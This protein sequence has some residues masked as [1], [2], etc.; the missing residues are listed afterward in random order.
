[1]D[2]Q[3]ALLPWEVKALAALDAGDRDS[4]LKALMEGLEQKILAY[5]ILRLGGDPEIG[6]DVAHEVFAAV[7]EAFPGFERKASLETWTFV[8]ARNRCAKRRDMI[9]HFGRIFSYG[10]DKTIEEAHP[11]PSDPPDEVVIKHQ[12][13][14]QLRRA[15]GKLR[16][17]ERDL[18]TM[19]YIEGLSLEKIAERYSVAREN[20]RLQL[21]K[22]L[23]KLKRVMD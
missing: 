17:K 1:M 8:I 20:V 2:N 7:W 14:E 22:A 21:L 6:K 18:V 23:Q 19:Y 9:R 13:I 10:I 15:M 11:D 16:H 4:A 3:D 5:C 12:Q